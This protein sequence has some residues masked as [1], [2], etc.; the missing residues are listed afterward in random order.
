MS[1]KAAQVLVTAFVGRSP[2]QFDAALRTDPALAADW[3]VPP[4]GVILYGANIPPPPDTAPKLAALVAAL[5]AR[6][7]AAGSRPRLLVSIDHEG[8]RF[9]H[10]GSE[11]GFTE[12][13]G[14]MALGA[15]AAASGEPGG[16]AGPAAAEAAARAAARAMA[17]EL[18]AVGV[19]LDYAPVLDINNNPAN[20]I[21]GER[22]F[23]Q[24]PWTVAALGEASCR[25]FVEGGVLPCG[26]HFPGHGDTEVDSHLGLPRV[27]HSLDRLRAV[28]LVPFARAVKAGLGAVM[29]AH[30]VFPAAAGLAPAVAPVGAAA[31]AQSLPATLSPAVLEGLLRRELGFD[32]VIITDALEMKAIADRWGVA[33][34]AVTALGAGADL[35]LLSRPGQ[36]GSVRE[37]IAAAV[38]EGRLAAERLD[39][40][41]RLVL[42]LKAAAAARPGDR[43]AERA[44]PAP[45][46]G[47]PADGA[48]P[49]DAA[50]HRRLAASIAARSVTLV[51]D[52]L[53]LLPL[54]PAGPGL[55]S[56]VSPT[57]E[58]VEALGRVHAPVRDLP[59][60][61]AADPSVLAEVRSAARSSEVVFV[62][63]RMTGGVGPV[64]PRRSRSTARGAEAPALLVEAAL[65]SGRPVIWVALG[66]PYDLALLPRAPVYLATYSSSR[67]SLQALADVVTGR[68]RPLGRLPVSIPGLYGAG[69]GLVTFGQNG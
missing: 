32:G 48:P 4:G 10:L 3:A 47:A 30:I 1:E 16:A 41:V 45:A 53:G 54:D 62:A 36:A 55:W 9:T 58:L 42:E 29:T 69:H 38:R 68:A 5:R 25:G 52:L 49:F 14:N 37:A 40:A 6:A 17:A 22:S 20:P 18:A 19:D 27:P 7:E 13:P 59:Y 2:E 15:I 56:V 64:A 61:D 46:A 35:I 23:G 12:F 43:P 21:I 51:R 60:V 33:E 57:P 11:H 24:D 26:K 44:A 65:D 28:E 66:T 63:T 50:A 31:H 8:G 39:E 34:A 67:P